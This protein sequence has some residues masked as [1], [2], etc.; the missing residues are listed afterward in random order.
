MVLIA[1][2]DTTTTVGTTVVAIAFVIAFTIDSIV[3]M[4]SMFA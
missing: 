3:S 1:A 2:A 4:H